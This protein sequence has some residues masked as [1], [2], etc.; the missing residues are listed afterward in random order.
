MGYFSNGTEG[1]MW[2]KENCENGC[3]HNIQDPSRGGGCPVLLA[4]L[5]FNYDQHENKQ[6]KE[7]LDILIPEGER[8]FI[9]YR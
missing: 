1:A 5:L 3:V 8:G 6:L 4:H 2:E 9:V 7:V